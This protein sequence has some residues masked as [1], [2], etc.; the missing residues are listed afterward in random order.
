MSSMTR[1][2]FGVLTSR[3]CDVLQ[4]QAQGYPTKTIAYD[5]G[6]RPRT[7]E[8]HR[9]NIVTKLKARSLS[10]VLRIAFAGG[11]REGRS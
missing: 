8:V 7:V 2:A 10:Q 5:L 6:I 4:G 9:T 11:L 1:K 3:E